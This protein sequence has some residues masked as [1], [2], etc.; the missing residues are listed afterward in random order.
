MIK[1]VRLASLH[2]SDR[3]MTILASEQVVSAIFNRADDE[4][5]LIIESDPFEPKEKAK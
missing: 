4:V 2:L 3:A 1:T 5:L